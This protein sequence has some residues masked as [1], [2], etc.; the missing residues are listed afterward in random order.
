MKVLVEF[1]LPEEE[2]TMQ[3]HLRGPAAHDCLWEFDQH[4]RGQ[5]KHGD[6][7]E[8]LGDALQALR[9]YLHQVCW[10]HSVLLD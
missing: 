7:S 10:E 5:I 6:I 3:R 4:L 1:D 9:D 8:E 2:N